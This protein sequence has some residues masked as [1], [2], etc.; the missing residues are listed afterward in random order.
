MLGLPLIAKDHL[1]EAIWDGLDPP[2][3]DL[4]WSRRVGGAAME[5]LWALAESMT[6]VMLEANFRPHSDREQAR[7]RSLRGIV[8][9]VYCS[10]SPEEAARRYAE[11]AQDPT[12]HRAH[13]RSTLDPGF[14]AEFD[15]PMG[16]GSLICVD[17]TSPVDL[18]VLARSVS[19]ELAHA[20]GKTHQDPTS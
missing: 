18:D 8:V 9:E 6:E 19:D 15:R 14:V 20:Q 1:K 11:R 5:V 7:L 12:H 2:A 10:C 17:T 4:E 13:V 3:A 16:V